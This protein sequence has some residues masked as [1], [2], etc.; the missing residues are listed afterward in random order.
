[1][2]SQNYP[3]LAMSRSVGDL[4]ASSIGVTCD[5]GNFFTFFIFICTLRNFGI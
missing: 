1:M 2:K 3:G 4:V 5:P